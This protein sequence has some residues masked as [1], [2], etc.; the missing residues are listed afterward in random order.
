MAILVCGRGGRND[1]FAPLQRSLAAEGI[2]VGCGDGFLCPAASVTRA[3]AAAFL[4]L[5]L[6]PPP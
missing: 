6:L 3:Q 1:A 2:T 4:S 5:F